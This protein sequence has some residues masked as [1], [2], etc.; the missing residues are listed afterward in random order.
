MCVG[1]EESERTFSVQYFA[2]SCFKLAPKKKK[3]GSKKPAVV[4]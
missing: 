3:R 2:V 4:R 1:V